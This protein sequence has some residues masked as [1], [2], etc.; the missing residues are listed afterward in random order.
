MV[1][2][3]S[4]RDLSWDYEGDEVVIRHSTNRLED[5]VRSRQGS[6]EI[7]TLCAFKIVTFREKRSL[8]FGLMSVKI[9]N[10]LTS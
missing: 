9:L 10:I 4:G 1:P 7:T 6:P 2:S 3:E 5:T 8:N